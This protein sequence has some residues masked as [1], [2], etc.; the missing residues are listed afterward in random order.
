MKKLTNKEKAKSPLW[1]WD[2]KKGYVFIGPTIINEEKENI[3][4]SKEFEPLEI[5]KPKKRR[6]GKH[7]A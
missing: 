4:L 2:S 1:T 6:G 7:G 5:R 3:Y